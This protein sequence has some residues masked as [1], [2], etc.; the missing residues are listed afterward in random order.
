MDNN[1]HPTFEN[2]K[3][4]YIEIPALDVQ[5]SSNFYQNVF[6]WNIWED[7]GGNISFDDTVG[8]VSGMWVLDREPTTKP[9]LLIS[10]MVYNVSDTLKLIAENHG[11]VVQNPDENASEVIARFSDPAGNVFC[12]YQVRQPVGS[13]VKWIKWI[14]GIIMAGVLT[15]GTANIVMHHT[16]KVD[17]NNLTPFQ[18]WVQFLI[19]P[20]LSFGLFL[21]L[22]CLFALIQKKY[23]GL[24]VFILSLI[25]IALGTYQHYMDDGFLRKDYLVRYIGFIASLIIS[26][27]LSYKIFRQN[28]WTST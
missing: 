10:I 24:L 14:L 11:K 3:I 15:L 2:G 28:K 19:V 12:L 23:A 22:S 1:L 17:M 21:F 13:F 6:G 8:Q 26:F 20:S 27:A 9:G 25:F 7:N 5:Q 16:G 18:Y 4:C